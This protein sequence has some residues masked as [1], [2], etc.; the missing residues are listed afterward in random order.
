M[1]TTPEWPFGARHAWHWLVILGIHLLHATNAFDGFAI[2][3]RRTL[4]EKRKPSLRGGCNMSY[5]CK[6]HPDGHEL[7]FARTL[8]RLPHRVQLLLRKLLRG[9]FRGDPKIEFL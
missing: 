9:G 2:H 5:G 7:W 8:N 1:G 4:I 6:P 3:P